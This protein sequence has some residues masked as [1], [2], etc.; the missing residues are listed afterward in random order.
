MYIL[1][2]FRQSN[3][4]GYTLVGERRRIDLT[5][6]T[7][8]VKPF[9]ARTNDADLTAYADDAVDKFRQLCQYYEN[10][11]QLVN[12]SDFDV[13]GSADPFAE[14]EEAPEQEEASEE[15]EEPE[16]KPKPKPKSTRSRRTT[17]PKEET[18]E[19]TEGEEPDTE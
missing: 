16:P 4:D 19:P 5:P 12:L 3:I 6:G 8:S 13:S 9:G 11:G 7:L 2:N 17:K 18:P 14:A 1:S 15:E 10:E